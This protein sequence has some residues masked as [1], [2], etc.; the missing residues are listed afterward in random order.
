MRI[1]RIFRILRVVFAILLFILVTASFMFFSHKFAVVTRLLHLQFVP[2]IL[3]ASGVGL[4]TLSVTII[5]TLIFG[6]VYCSWICPLGVWQDMVSRIAGWFKGN[7]RKGRLSHRP[8]YVYHKPHPW[9]RWSILTL[10][11][12]F[13]F[14]G[15]SFPL[16]ALDPYSNWGRISTALFS[17]LIQFFA[18][19]LSFILPERVSYTPLAEFSA[20]IFI[21]ALVFFILVTS[22]SFFRGRLY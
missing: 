17:P 3:A 19:I 14:I 7:N 10:V 22:M 9:L 4:I 2:S 16:T 13:T 11:M 15:F 21:S 20:A 12:V 18:N 1:Y 5:L 6:R 8:K